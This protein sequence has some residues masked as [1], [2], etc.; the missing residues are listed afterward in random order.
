MSKQS[1]TS[2]RVTLTRKDDSQAVVV[3]RGEYTP[4][5]AGCTWGPPENCREAT[6]SELAVVEVRGAGY[7]LTYPTSTQADWDAFYCEFGLDTD[8]GWN[9][10]MAQVDETDCAVV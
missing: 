6:P 5:D 8:D 4:A 9:A 7:E 1:L 2:F 3:L 10:L